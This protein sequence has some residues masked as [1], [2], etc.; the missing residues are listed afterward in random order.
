MESRAKD[1]HSGQIKIL[2]NFD[3]AIGDVLLDPK[4]IHRCLINLIS[5]A[6]DACLADGDEQK[7]H[8]VQVT[9]RLEEKGN[10]SIQVSDNGC[11]MDE[12]VL[13][14]LFTSFFRT[15]G[16]RGAGLGL[17]VTQKIVQEHGGV[18]KVI[19]TYGEGSTFTIQL[20]LKR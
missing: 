19:S 10:F 3:P 7:S 14:K 9:T 4:G 11:G 15:K 6:I 20:P 8:A 12:E 16:S 2:R 13:K 18:M 5:N 1:T 17:L